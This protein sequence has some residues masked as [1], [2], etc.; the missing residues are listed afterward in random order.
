MEGNL[1]QITTTMKAQAEAYEEL[2]KA[3]AVGEQELQNKKKEIDYVISLCD[4][5]ISEVN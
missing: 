2:E 5:A 1:N 3:K 4:V